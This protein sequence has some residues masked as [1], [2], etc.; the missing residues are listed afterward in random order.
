M[1]SPYVPL[2][3]WASASSGRIGRRGQTYEWHE[4]RV[5]MVILVLGPNLEPSDA[6]PIC[7]Q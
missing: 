5:V 6:L 1:E 4:H 3:G 7:D 2:N